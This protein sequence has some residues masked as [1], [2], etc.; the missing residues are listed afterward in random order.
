M[1]QPARSCSF[2][3]P[4]PD[5]RRGDARRIERARPDEGVGE[6][7]A[8]APLR[9]RPPRLVPAHSLPK[10][11]PAHDH[12]P[13]AGQSPPRRC[14]RPLA[15]GI[16]P[17]G[18]VVPVSHGADVTRSIIARTARICAPDFHA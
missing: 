5:A 15:P 2:A 14:A 3:T 17:G 1:R 8:D 11:P 4:A 7:T 16:P 12:T 9:T 6:H 18:R 13:R 10:R